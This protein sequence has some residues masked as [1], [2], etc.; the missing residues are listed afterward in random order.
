[1][2]PRKQPASQTAHPY[3][4]N[5]RKSSAPR[6]STALNV[7]IKKRVLKKTAV[8]KVAGKR[9]PKGHFLGAEAD[10]LFSKSS[11]YL[12]ASAA[13]TSGQMCLA[14]ARELVGSFGES[15]FHDGAVPTDKDAGMP[16]GDETSNEA[17]A[18]RHT[19]R[20]DVLSTVGC[21][22]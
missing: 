22:C 17:D 15:A 11:A 4:A 12:A 8:V 7:R 19:A 20:L 21:P 14:T 2:E 16:C 6:G 9:G 18:D 1:M 10:F 5:A 3:V 13:G